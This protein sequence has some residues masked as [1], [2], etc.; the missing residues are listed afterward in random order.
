M[1]SKVSGLVGFN[2]GHRVNKY[3]FLLLF[4]I[5]PLMVSAAQQ[6][7]PEKIPSNIKGALCYIQSDDQ[8]VFVKEVFTQK[9]SLPG[10]TIDLNEAANKAAERETWEETGLVVTAKEIL[11][12]T[13]TAVV[14]HCEP[15]SGVIA[16]TARNHHGFHVLPA[17]FAPDFGIETK[18]VLLGYADMIK[19]QEYRYPAQYHQ[20]VLN[21]DVPNAPIQYIDS[22]ISAAPLMH[23]F[24]L[25]V[26]E[27]IQ[28]TISLLPKWISA[29]IFDVLKVFNSTASIFGVLF[30]M[31]IMIYYFG[32]KPS[33]QM[34]YVGIVTVTITLLIQLGLKFPR[35]FIYL[36][37]LQLTDILGFS[38]PSIRTALSIVLIGYLFH[39]WKKMYEYE[40]IWRCLVLLIGVTLI[41]GLSSIMLGEQFISDV[42]F[43]YVIGLLILWHYIRL[44]DKQ[45]VAAK[46]IM[47]QP[48]LWWGSLGGLLI[49]AYSLHSIQ[50][51][52]LA[53]I[54]FA[55]VISLPSLIKVPHLT[56]PY[57]IVKMVATCLITYGIFIT[58]Q[59]WLTSITQS[60]ISGYFAQCGFWFVLTYIVI[61]ISCIGS[62][63]KK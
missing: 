17:W 54:T 39:I 58:Q 49:L 5:A 8:V 59:H 41:Q 29:F 1:A 55:F 36:P 28:S 12:Q 53:G 10:G 15:A 23:Q 13:E 38:T 18:Q 25:P 26:I 60:S 32:G 45:S 46:L 37:P 30:L 62:Y 48:A 50:L 61:K 35:P 6:P 33:L 19:P 7:V 43:G 2:L 16:F 40:S 44:D 52:N 57:L 22:A 42:L 47:L 20:Q 63:P 9:L 21:H 34:A 24:E 27:K 51:A 31:P 11:T 14:F 3:L 4:F 56:L